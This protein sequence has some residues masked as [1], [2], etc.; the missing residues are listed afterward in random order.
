MQLK[1]RNVGVL[2]GAFGATGDLISNILVGAKGTSKQGLVKIAGLPEFEF[3]DL[4]HYFKPQVFA[5]AVAGVYT[6][7]PT[8]A[9]DTTHTDVS[10]RFHITGFPNTAPQAERQ[11]AGALVSIGPDE[12][13]TTEQWCDRIVDAFAG[14]KYF[15][16]AKTGGA[17]TWAVTFTEKQTITSLDKQPQML[18]LH[19]AGAVSATQSFTKTT[20]TKPQ[21]GL[22]G[23]QL[24]NL[25]EVGYDREIAMDEKT[26]VKD[27][28]ID[29][30][31]N[32]DVIRFVFHRKS[33]V[34]PF[35]F[36]GNEP[37]SYEVY[38]KTNASNKSVFYT[39]LNALM[40]LNA[41]AFRPIFG[42]PVA[43][44]FANSGDLV[45]PTGPVPAAG[46]M[47]MIKSV[48]GSN[49]ITDEGIYYVITPTATTFQ[50]SLIRGGAA[51][52]ITADTTGT[53]AYFGH[54]LVALTDTSDLVTPHADYVPTD[55]EVVRFTGVNTTTGISANTDYYVVNATSTTFK[56][57][58]T[59]GGH[60]LELTTNG[61]A[62]MVLPW[63]GGA[64]P[65]VLFATP[66]YEF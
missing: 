28:D 27:T 49:G 36:A 59:R 32:Y 12:T 29:T 40:S 56:V 57:S 37:Y 30:A 21:V 45:T 13:L 38:V 48:S 61:S 31:A 6:Y 66:G 54:D 9:N 18:T 20:A 47:V 46:T 43:V 23:T 65:D 22:T 25:L 34:N 53:I 19:C 63:G 24:H 8:T 62:I 17:N 50:L 64:T 60:A 42:K 35:G 33:V 58:A 41:D 16:A 39:K 51:E 7:D 14:N 5:A 11:F 26:V 1:T 10:I 3:R 55:G 2:T 44:A 4:V 15:T 52:A